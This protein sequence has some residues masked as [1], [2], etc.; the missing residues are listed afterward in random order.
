MLRPAIC[1]TATSGLLEAILNILTQS[2]Q[3]DTGCF[4]WG[5]D[6]NFNRQC[7]IN[8]DH[9]DNQTYPNDCNGKRVIPGTP[10]LRP[11]RRPWR[12]LK[13]LLRADF[14]LFFRVPGPGQSTGGRMS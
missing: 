3:P 2:F 1:P 4:G 11:V 8:S 7:R 14:L 10:L 13:Q 9:D 5:H 12:V 6:V